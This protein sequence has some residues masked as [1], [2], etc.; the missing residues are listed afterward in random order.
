MKY[1]IGGFSNVLS[2]QGKN[3]F[4][5]A[6]SLQVGRVYGVVTTEN[7]PSE[8]MFKKAGGFN[9][10]GSI[11]YLDYNSAKNVTGTGDEFL[12]LCSIA[13]P[14]SPQFQYYP[15]LGE[16][17][18][19]L[20]APSP[21]TQ[22]S[23][24]S[25]SNQKYYTSVVNLWNNNQQN[26]QPADDSDNLGITFVENANIKSLLS[27][28]GDHI[29]Q[30]RQGNALRFSSTTKLYND[31]NEWSDVGNDDSPI[32][33]L[34]NGFAYNPKEKFHVEK[35]NQD[36]SSIYLT[37]TQQL[38]LQTDKTG[39]LNPLTKPVDTSKYFNAQV[40]INSDRVV[41]NSKRDEVMIF[42]KSNI[43]L[44]TK[45]I[46]NLNAN[47]RVHL[48]SNTVFLGTVNNSLPTEPL[49]LGDKLNTLLETLLDSLYNFGN[50]LSSV[51]GSPEGAPA[52]DINMA[53]EG[54]LNDIDRINDNLE[55]ILSQQN[56]TA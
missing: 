10:I 50:A 33:I 13:R 11:F 9:G 19:L 21:D 49:V 48:N 26:S 28:E 3:N 25:T 34:S 1:Q 39:I 51:V 24:N 47:E 54:L 46:I 53:A 14:M 5:A 6:P 23:L 8:A 20:D 12:D 30:G 52:M 37:S 4:S 22:R 31:L 43:E 27:F 17:V 32:T 55:G 41:L 36:A 56:F 7:T 2:A 29:V 45:N 16:L 40:V 35:I 15:I 42:A 38:P 18:A 44:N